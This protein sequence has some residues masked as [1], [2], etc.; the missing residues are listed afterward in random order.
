V[1]HD[2]GTR[3][4]QC[5]DAALRLQP[6]SVTRQ[7]LR[8]EREALERLEASAGALVARRRRCHPAWRTSPLD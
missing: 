6:E 7:G 1:D 3:A 2:A 5:Y 4:G 8:R